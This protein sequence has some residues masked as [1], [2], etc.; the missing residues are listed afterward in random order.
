[1]KAIWTAAA[2]ML[3]SV[4]VAQAATNVTPPDELARNTANALLEELKT[5]KES[6]K[7]N[8]E[9]LYAVVDR[10][11]LPHFDFDYVS[12]LVLA[13]YW[14]KATPEQRTRFQQA[15]RS[16]LV[17]FYGDAL[18]DYSDETVRW[19]DAPVPEDATDVTVKSEIVPKGGDPIQISYATHLTDGQWK[20]Y[21]VTV[22]GISLVTNYRGQFA[23]EIRRNGLDALIQR[24]ESESNAT[25]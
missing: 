21:D 20:V 11:V 15:F 13:R 24:L 3:L 25:S 4:S 18:L 2:A 6:F 1:M 7:Q 14:R 22:D 17:S 5:N 10:I 9:Q 8:P 23:A 16:Q 12:K 19:E